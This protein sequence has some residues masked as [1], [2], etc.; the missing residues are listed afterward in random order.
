MKGLATLVDPMPVGNLEGNLLLAVGL[1]G[2]SLVDVLTG[3]LD[4]DGN[5]REPAGDEVSQGGIDLALQRVGGRCFLQARGI[6]RAQ[7]GSRDADGRGDA[8]KATT[9]EERHLGEEGHVGGGEDIR[10]SLA[11]GPRT[12]KRTSGR[13]LDARLGMAS[14]CLAPHPRTSLRLPY[15]ITCFE[16]LAATDYSRNRQRPLTVG[17]TDRPGCQTRWRPSQRPCACSR[18]S[19][20]TPGQRAPGPCGD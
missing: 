2:R 7:L 11:T 1:A 5:A 13:P 12:G 10:C 19:C 4:P 14:S 17:K 20:R 9:A 18:P 3:L 16:N 6:Q 8:E 15:R